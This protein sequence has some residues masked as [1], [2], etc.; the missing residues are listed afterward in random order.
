[1]EFQEPQQ[2]A[3]QIV[4]P[5][6]NEKRRLSAELSSEVL[7]GAGRAEEPRLQRVCDAKP[8]SSPITAEVRHEL[9]T[10]VEVHQHLSNSALRHRLEHAVDHGTTADRKHRLRGVHGDRVVVG[11]RIAGVGECRVESL[12]EEAD[13]VFPVDWRYKLREEVVKGLRR[14]DNLR[15]TNA[16]SKARD[17]LPQII[18]EAR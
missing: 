18:D 5:V 12:E 16:N 13:C 2:V 6:D 3:L 9:R 7:Y 17:D 8:P 14:R 4:V 11:A 10:V 15:K 1:M